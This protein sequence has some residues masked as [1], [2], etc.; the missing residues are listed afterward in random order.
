MT[1]IHEI[2]YPCFIYK[3]TVKYVYC[4]VE[5]LLSGIKSAQ[6]ISYEV[7]WIAGQVGILQLTCIS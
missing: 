6:C 5:I 4:T 7:Q 2:S 3:Y 1:H